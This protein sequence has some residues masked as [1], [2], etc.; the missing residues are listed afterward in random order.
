MGERSSSGFRCWPRPASCGPGANFSSG[1]RRRESPPG[2]EATA[3]GSDFDQFVIPNRNARWDQSGVENH[4]VTGVG[5]TRL[6]FHNK[7]FRLIEE[8]LT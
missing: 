2:V 6:L 3:I 4:I 5:H 8:A 7:T 1:S